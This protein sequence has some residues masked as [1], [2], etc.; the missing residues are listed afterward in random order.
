MRISLKAVP[1]CYPVFYLA[2]PVLQDR[3]AALE[4]RD[5]ITSP[6]RVRRPSPRG[7]CYRGQTENRTLFRRDRDVA[8]STMSAPVRPTPEAVTHA[9]TD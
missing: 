1:T 7:T 2:R 6:A 5:V 8:L 9:L 3:V 4:G